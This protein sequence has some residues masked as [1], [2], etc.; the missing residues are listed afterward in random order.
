MAM[1]EADWEEMG[2][3]ELVRDVFGGLEGG[4]ALRLRAGWWARW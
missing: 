3:R 2:Y 4:G 1:G